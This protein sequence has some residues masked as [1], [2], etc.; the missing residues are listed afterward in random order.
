MYTVRNKLFRILKQRV[1]LVLYHVTSINILDVAETV[2]QRYTSLSGPLMLHASHSVPWC[3]TP[4]F[5]LVWFG[6]FV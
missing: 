3:Y 4:L 6:F 5:G 2:R 1:N